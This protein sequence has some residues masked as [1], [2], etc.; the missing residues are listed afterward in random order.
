MVEVGVQLE[1]G[2]LLEKDGT[3]KCPYL[4]SAAY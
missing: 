4:I 2:E 1:M 3:R